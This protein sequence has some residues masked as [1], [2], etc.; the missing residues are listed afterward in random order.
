VQPGTVLRISKIWLLLL[1]WPTLG[2][3]QDATPP[4][5]D[6]VSQL[7]QQIK[8]LQQQEL[9]LQ[10]RIRVLESKQTSSP[11]AQASAPLPV[12]PTSATE[13][14]ASS[15]APTAS[16]AAQ[17][18]KLDAPTAVPAPEL[19]A[20]RGVQWR[21]FAEV[22]YKILSQ[23]TP[24][25]GTYGFVPGSSGSFYTG[26]FDL[27][28]TSRLSEK[29]D[30]LAEFAVEEGDAQSFTVDLRRMLLNYDVGDHMKVS[31]GRY[32][33]NIGYY[34]WAFR[35]AAWL[36]TTA[37]RPL[38]MEFAS[39]GGLLPTQA[40]GVSVTGT[41]PS[42]KLGLNYVAEYG[43]S[44]TIRPDINGSGL[45]NDENNGNHIDFGVFLTPDPF[46][47]LRI[48]GSYYHDQISDLVTTELGVPVQTEGEGLIIPPAS[49]RWNQTIVN[50]HVV[51]VSHGIESLNEAFLIRFA[52]TIATAGETFNT[53]S[54]YSQFSKSVGPIRPFVRF[55]YTNASPR[56]YIYNDVGLRYGPSF[57][58]RY[59]LTE[60]LAFKAQLDDTVRRGLPNLGGLHLQ[61]SGTF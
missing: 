15:S 8:Q 44:D 30:L 40:V 27:F 43:S 50:G 9:G 35:S 59:D 38:V 46:P 52:P 53:P 45:L 23:R 6:A 28:L 17:N 36:Q 26:D 51:Y 2:R 33:T 7:E 42:G 34:N 31:F 19:H 49:A 21:G 13:D 3:G 11:A 57:G 41:I 55:Q 54:F 16:T 5:A 1:V 10:E 32:Q 48:G 25:T 24:E 22:D 4:N 61:I 39:D 56:D 18:P 37:D 47:G 14:Q 12:S 58:A 20:F 29:S 60:Y